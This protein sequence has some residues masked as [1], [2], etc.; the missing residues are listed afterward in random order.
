VRS[1]AGNPSATDAAAAGTGTW[2]G[3]GEGADSLGAAGRRTGAT[4][5]CTRTEEA[6]LAEDAATGAAA[7][8]GSS[9][10]FVAVRAP[11][12]IRGLRAAM[13]LRADDAGLRRVTPLR[14]GAFCATVWA[15]GW[16][17]ALW[18]KCAVMLSPCESVIT[19]I[20]NPATAPATVSRRQAR[21]Y[22]QV[23]VSV[24]VMFN[25]SLYHFFN[26]QTIMKPL[27][28]RLRAGVY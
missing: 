25:R 26:D 28:V 4:L 27:T 10:R 24:C 2:V 5:E 21:R 14:A 3:A 8:I 22:S 11:A 18:K 12:C 16:H 15:G 13:L 20:K 23:F 7:R 17:A 9:V 1:N 19:P 6:A